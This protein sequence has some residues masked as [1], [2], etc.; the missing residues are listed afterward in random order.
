[1]KKTLK[2]GMHGDIVIYQAADGGI[3]LDLRFD[4]GTVWLDQG[5]MAALFDKNTDTVGL[6]IRN[7]YKEGELEKKFTTEES[8]VVQ[9]EGQGSIRRLVRYYNLDIIISAGY[10]VISLR[11]KQFRIWAMRVLW[12][13]LIKGYTANE[14]RVKESWQSVRLV[15]RNN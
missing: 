12:E 10:R 1:M 7:I 9:T 8:S 6:H 2:S 13:H 5:Q 14:K 3:S 11:G 15:N 4:R